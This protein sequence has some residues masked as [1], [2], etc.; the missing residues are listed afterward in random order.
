MYSLNVCTIVHSTACQTSMSTGGAAPV[1]GVSSAGS[2]AS[3]SQGGYLTGTSAAP[4]PLL[5]PASGHPSL[6][7]FP[8][9]SPLP[10][11][12]C[13]PAIVKR[14]EAPSVQLRLMV[15]RHRGISSPRN[16]L[17]VHKFPYVSLI[18]LKTSADQGQC[19]MHGMYLCVATA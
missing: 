2:S 12:S 11:P 6:A 18:F 7:C 3:A 8:A 14:Q 10:P 19:R 17:A 15:S 4:S 16:M 9:A 5:R 13:L 1:V